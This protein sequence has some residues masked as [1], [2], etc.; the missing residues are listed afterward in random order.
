MYCNAQMRRELWPVAFMLL[1]GLA[2]CLPPKPEP[3]VV[4]RIAS[5]G[6]V[7]DDSDAMRI[8]QEVFAE[9]ERRHPGVQIQ[10]ERIP[11]PQDYVRKLLLSFVAHAEPDVIRLDASSAAVF[12]DNGVL[13]D[14]TPYVEGPNGIELTDYYPNVV[15]IARRDRALYAIPVDFTPLV[16]Y[17]NRRM[18]DDAGVP[19][20]EPGWTWADFL[21]KARKLTQGEQY[22]YVF[23]N[24]MPGWLPWV[25]NNGGDIVNAHGESMGIAD[26]AATVEAVTWL[27][28]LVTKEKVAPSL[29]QIAAEGAD[30]FAN[31]QAAMET[32]GHWRMVSFASAR[33]IKLEDVGVAPLPVARSGQSP[34]TVIYESGWSIGRS[35]KN[36]D[37]AWEFIKYYTSAEVQRKLQQTGIGVCARKDIAQERAT[38]EREQKFL[39]IIPSGRAPWGATIQ[40]YD[41]VE[42][43]GQREMDAILKSGRDPKVVL[44]RLARSIE[45]ELNE[46]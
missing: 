27:R 36:P 45:R 33:N 38:D 46:P 15:D 24:W 39:N 30:L 8:E 22:G 16:V 20:P 40:G 25:W 37:L 34:V 42:A 5:W 17:Y 43:E 7:G 23:T 35:C 13:K 9:F 2:G 14:L 21:A 18:F 11:N 19:Y 31:G 12:I 10:Q 26:S 44:G 32:S 29:S 3:V 4:L 41:F 28:N 6:G 1:L